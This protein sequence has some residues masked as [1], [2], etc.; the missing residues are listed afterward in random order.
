M[1]CKVL[2]IPGG[3]GFLPSSVWIINRVWGSLFWARPNGRK[4]YFPSERCKETFLEA[5][6]QLKK[7]APWV[8]ANS[9]WINLIQCSKVCLLVGKWWS[10]IW[11]KYVVNNSWGFVINGRTCWQCTSNL[12][13]HKWE[14][15]KQKLRSDNWLAYAEGLLMYALHWFWQLVASQNQIFP[16]NPC[17]LYN[18]GSLKAIWFTAVYIWI[19]SDVLLYPTKKALSRKQ[20]VQMNMPYY[21]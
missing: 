15:I 10:K 17:H 3:A 9:N 21:I 11:L 16:T 7:Y 14:L 19:Y 13:T 2:Y 18:I 1:Y 8:E 6:S 5:F 4:R 12:K 20:P